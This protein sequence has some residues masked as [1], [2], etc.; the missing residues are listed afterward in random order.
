MFSNIK[1]LVGYAALYR[2]KQN[3]VDILYINTYECDAW[4]KSEL[5]DMAEIRTFE[6]LLTS[7]VKK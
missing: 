1:E 2:A 5:Q 3:Y 6:Q 4:T 7:R